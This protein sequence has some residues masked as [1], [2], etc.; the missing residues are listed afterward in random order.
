MVRHLRS[1]HA[2]DGA[3]Q[4]VRH[5]ADRSEVIF[6]RQIDVA[7]TCEASRALVRPVTV[8]KGTD[9]GILRLKRQTSTC[10]EV[11]E[12]HPCIE[13]PLPLSISLAIIVIIVCLCTFAGHY[14][15]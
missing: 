4:F 1:E 2:G 3:D 7:R 9:H 8:G 14:E 6:H 5:G 13:K 10:A 15:I 11:A 12:S